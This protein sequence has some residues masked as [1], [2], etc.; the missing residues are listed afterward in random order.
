MINRI[1][2]DRNSIIIAG[3]AILYLC[4]LTVDSIA[5][6]EIND[7]YI[8]S[9]DVQWVMGTASVERIVVLEKGRF[10]LKSFKHKKFNLEMVSG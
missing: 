3:I 8:K 10:V 4:F 7:A 6:Q 1:F 2:I 9:S 5:A